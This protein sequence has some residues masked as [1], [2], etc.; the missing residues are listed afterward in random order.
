MVHRNDTDKL[1]IHQ[2]KSSIL[3]HNKTY[4]GLPNCK[5]TAEI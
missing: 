5:D 1:F 4:M 3:S 2:S